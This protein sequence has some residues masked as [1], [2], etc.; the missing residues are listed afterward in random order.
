MLLQCGREVGGSK[1]GGNSQLGNPCSHSGKE[2]GREWMDLRESQEV[3]F[4]GC[5]V[6]KDRV[7]G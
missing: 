7:W 5:G 2:E 6:W 1:S 4:T 3:G